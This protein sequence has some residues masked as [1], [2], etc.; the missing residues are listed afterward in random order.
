MPSATDVGPQAGYVY[1]D[2]KDGLGYYRDTQASE[3]KV[4]LKHV[5]EPQSSPFG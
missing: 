4:L 1:K 3:W 5:Y 2:G